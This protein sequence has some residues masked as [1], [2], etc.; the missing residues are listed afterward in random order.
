[1]ARETAKRM[2][3]ESPNEYEQKIRELAEAS[4]TVGKSLEE[5]V[6]AFSRARA[7]AISWLVAVSNITRETVE[8]IES[9]GK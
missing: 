4:A 9:D 3:T 1:M 8:K 2:A 6:A 5:L 7:D